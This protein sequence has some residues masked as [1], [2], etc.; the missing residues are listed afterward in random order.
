MCGI[1]LNDK[2]FFKVGSDDGVTAG[3]N[4]DDDLVAGAIPILTLAGNLASRI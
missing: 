3:I 1:Q 2:L 4:R